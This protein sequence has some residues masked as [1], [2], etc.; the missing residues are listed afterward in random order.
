MKGRGAFVAKKE[1]LMQQR[2]EVYWKE[3][4]K[5]L[6]KGRELGIEQED[7]IK[8]TKEFWEV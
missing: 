3:Y 8:K 6:Q 2:L 7:F 5:L 4:Q 1:N